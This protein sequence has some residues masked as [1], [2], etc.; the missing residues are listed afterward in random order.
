MRKLRKSSDSEEH[1]VSEVHG[2]GGVGLKECPEC[3]CP[4]FHHLRGI[5]CTTIVDWVENPRELPDPLTEAIRKGQ[6]FLMFADHPELGAPKR[7]A[8]LCPCERGIA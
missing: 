2:L 6:S 5:G 8:I 1:G 3:R 7:T 4:A